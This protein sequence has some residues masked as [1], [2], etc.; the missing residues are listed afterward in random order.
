MAAAR[1]E[2]SGRSLGSGAD[3][4]A[5]VIMW[6]E[7]AAC[8]YKLLLDP[9]RFT[10]APSAKMA[11]AFWDGKIKPIVA[12]RLGVRSAGRPRHEKR[13]GAPEQR[14]VRFWDARSCHRQREAHSDALVFRSR[15]VSRNRG[16]DILQMRDRGRLHGRR[17]G[18]ASVRR[19]YRATGG[20]RRSGQFA[21]HQ[22]DRARTASRML[23]VAVSRD[24]LTASARS[25]CAERQAA[26]GVEE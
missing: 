8:E 11:N 15:A 13:F 21:G 17:R 18:A 6:R 16:R 9:E 4:R 25:G 26:V 10:G 23:G 22:Q 2:R 20:S 19:V 12:R 3:R 1:S 24:R 5:S 14:I 7:L